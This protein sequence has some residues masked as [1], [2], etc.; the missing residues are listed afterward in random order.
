MPRTH[1]PGDGE[2]LAMVQV[3][4]QTTEAKGSLS[5]GWDARPFAE[6]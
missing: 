3:K 5:R 1:G 2:V 4:A 6:L